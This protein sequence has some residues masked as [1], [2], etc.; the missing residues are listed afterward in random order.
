M[1]LLITI[2]FL[3]LSF[4][5]P[6]QP[7]SIADKNV[8]KPKLYADIAK[9]AD[10][11]WRVNKITTEKNRIDFITLKPLGFDQSEWDCSKMLFGF[12]TFSDYRDCVPPGS[13]FRTSK[14]RALPTALLGVSTF[15]ATLISGLIIEESIFDQAAY[16][17]AVAEALRNSGLEGER[18][19]GIIKRFLALSELTSARNKEL[20][21][22]FGRYKDEYYNNAEQARVEKLIEDESGLYTNDLYPDIMIR[23][24][25]N[26]L[27][28]LR[29]PAMPAVSISGEAAEF[30]E[31]L[32]YMEASLHD[33]K[34][35][36][37]DALRN[38]TR[39]YP[40]FC[41]PEHLQ[42][43]H[44]KYDCPSRV[45]E[46]QETVARAIIVAKDIS[47]ALPEF[48]E[49]EDASIKVL[50]QKDKLFIENRTAE[51]LSVTGASLSYRGASSKSFRPAEVPPSSRIE[52]L[53]LYK[54]ITHEIEKAAS[55]ANM[56]LKEA[57]NTSV[58]VSLT[59]TYEHQN[60]KK[61]LTGERT[62]KLSDLISKESIL[63]SRPAAL[64]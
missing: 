52:A 25:R 29:P 57:E 7:Q 45:A 53:G 3:A 47:G 55:F 18:R 43:Y 16:D 20:S 9:G 61:T 41:G 13:E 36:L 14:K 37:E 59:V 32:S 10:G 39:D 26:A 17:R 50:W 27:S 5:P 21:E 28:E 12:F 30:E 49:A 38:A 2:V 42:P 48:F 54:L 1:P 34:T 58:G 33:E 35:A 19:E 40:V 63:K 44:I 62:F 23:V 64:Q 8:A 4:F 56:T 15:G 22:L 60:A 24:N 6:F 31:K 11:Q 51:K 46:G